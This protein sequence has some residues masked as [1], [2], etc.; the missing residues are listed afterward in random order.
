MQ[1]DALECVC[2]AGRGTTRVKVSRMY[3]KLRDGASGS[4]ISPHIQFWGNAVREGRQAREGEE[5]G[6]SREVAPEVDCI[7]DTVI[8]S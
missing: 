4:G 2:A 3:A 5:K 1:T 8:L 6:V 7:L